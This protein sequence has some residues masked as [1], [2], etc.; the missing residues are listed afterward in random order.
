M[1]AVVDHHGG[2]QHES[3]PH[4][5]HPLLRLTRVAL[6][7]PGLEQRGEVTQAVYPPRNVAWGLTELSFH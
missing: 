2:E 4:G 3:G 1:V 6:A 5:E 7:A